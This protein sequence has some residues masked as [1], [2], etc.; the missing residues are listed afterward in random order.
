MI[1]LLLVWW[2]RRGPWPRAERRVAVAAMSCCVA[3]RSSRRRGRCRSRRWTGGP[4]RIG[5]ESWIW[6]T[7][8][9]GSGSWMTSVD[10]LCWH[11]QLLLHEFRPEVSSD[12]QDVVVEVVAWIVKAATTGPFETVA[13]I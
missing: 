1:R 2:W 7:T 10:L 8:R 9:I 13:D 6:G 12:R 11:S 5:A 3:G 4:T